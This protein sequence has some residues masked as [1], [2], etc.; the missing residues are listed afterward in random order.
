MHKTAQALNDKELDDLD[1]YLLSDDMPES[2]MDI[3]VL[4]RLSQTPTRCSV[5]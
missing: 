5:S 2:A 1:K 4:I 3:S